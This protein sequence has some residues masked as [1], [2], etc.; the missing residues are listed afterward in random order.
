MH[1]NIEP[2]A[3][4]GADGS[5]DSSTDGSAN[6][7]TGGLDT[8]PNYARAH[9]RAHPVEPTGRSALRNPSSCYEVPYADAL[10]ADATEPYVR[11]DSGSNNCTD[12]C[13]YACVRPGD[14]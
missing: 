9:T 12:G 7:C 2:H 13:A 10:A 3:E 5:A 8:E 6:A 14:V 11:A 1:T 4:P